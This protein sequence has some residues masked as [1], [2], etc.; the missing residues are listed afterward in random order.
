MAAST[1]VMPQLYT[2]FEPYFQTSA[3]NAAEQC[4]GNA[5]GILN[6]CGLRWTDGSRWD[7]TYGVGQQMAA[8]E[9]IQANLIQGARHPVSKDTGGTSKGNPSAG[10]GG[11][12]SVPGAAP[13]GQV[14]TGDKAGASVLTA[15]VLV[16]MLGGTWWMIV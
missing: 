6:A 9:I 12:I 2:D 3:H 8:L 10:T 5:A 11:D 1:K 16:G 13:V 15:V 7:G 4:S 14:K